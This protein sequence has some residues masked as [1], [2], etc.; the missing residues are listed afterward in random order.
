MER[1]KIILAPGNGN[2]SPQDNWFPYI[3]RELESLGIPVLTESFPDPYLARSSYWIPFLKDTLG[4][5]ENTIIIGHSSGA[6]AAMRFAESYPLLGSVL[7]GAMHTHLGLETEIQSG[8]FD[9]PWNWDAQKR[10]QHWIV[11]FASCDDPWIPIEEARFVQNQLGAEYYEY[12]DQGHFGG[13]Y[14][15][16]EFSEL[17][18]VLRDKLSV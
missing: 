15:K 13:D 17:L 12:A 5:D 11:Q 14:Y 1:R 16:P 18:A 2:S 3:K 8:Y 9:L 7:V 4:A 6:L 10:N